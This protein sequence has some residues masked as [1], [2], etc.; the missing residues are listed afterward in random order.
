MQKVAIV[1]LYAPHAR[2]VAASGLATG[3]GVSR[4]P[5]PPWYV[6]SKPYTPHPRPSDWW[7][8]PTNCH[9]PK[10]INYRGPD[11]PPVER[12]FGLNKGFVGRARYPS[13]DG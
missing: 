8:L 7:G 4:S 9:K 6:P 2:M 3:D 1:P 12:N 11:S 10:K 5:P 13:T